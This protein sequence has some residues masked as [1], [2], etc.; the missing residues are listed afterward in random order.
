MS[1]ITKHYNSHVMDE[2]DNKT[3]QQSCLIVVYLV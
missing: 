2:Y 1:M 3:L